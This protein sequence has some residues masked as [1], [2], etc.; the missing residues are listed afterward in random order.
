VYAASDRAL[1]RRVAVK[2]I[3][4]DLVGSAET[5]ERF[6]RE[7]RVAA[8][9]S[10]PNVVIV[11]D[12][13]VTAGTRAFLV[14]ELLEGSTLREGL[15]RQKR[16]PT[17][18]VLS[19]LRE[20]CAALE[21]AHRRQLVHRDLKPENI[22]LVA[23]DA[24]ET[25]KLLDFGIA[26]FLPIDSL[27]PTVD[28]APGVLLGTL[29]YMSPEQWHGGEAHPSWDLWALAVVAYELLTGSYPF[30]GRSPADW[31][32]AG[33]VA[34]FT[35]VST[36]LPEAPQSWQELFERAFATEPTRRPQSAETFL[37]ELQSTLV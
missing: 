29:R 26:K 2:V 17:S 19:V 16:F 33:P 8:S 1:E 27:G 6:R 25:A 24:R 28:T 11:H 15:C 22:F 12:F 34:K 13:G 3:R 9:F 20:V 4:E 21:A 37:S 18:R 30:D 31:F 23:G 5:A 14:M 36:N 7:A 10:H 35:P 32:G